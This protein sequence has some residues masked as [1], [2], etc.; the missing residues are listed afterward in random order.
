MQIPQI[1]GF[2]DFSMLLSCLQ[3]DS[4]GFLIKNGNP[5]NNYLLKKNHGTPA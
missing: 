4:E 1:G 2:F 3:M 5:S